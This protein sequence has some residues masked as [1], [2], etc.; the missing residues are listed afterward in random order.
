MIDS[1]SFYLKAHIWSLPVS[2]LHSGPGNS[3]LSL[4]HRDNVLECQTDSF[5]G[6]IDG[7]MDGTLNEEWMET[8]IKQT[9]SERHSFTFTFGIITHL[10]TKDIQFIQGTVQ[11]FKLMDLNR[12][13]TQIQIKKEG[14]WVSVAADEE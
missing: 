5:N 6:W 12:K 10:F 9:M 3:T 7:W 14:G 1:P 2:L 4:L 8:K 11:T 13:S